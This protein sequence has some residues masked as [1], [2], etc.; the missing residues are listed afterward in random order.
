MAHLQANAAFVHRLASAL[1]GECGADLA[2]DA[3][4][5]SVQA[6]PRGCG[7]GS[8]WR[9]IV[10]RLAANA[11]RAERRRRAHHEARTAAL[12]GEDIVSLS[13]A[14]VLEREETRRR[15]LDAVLALEEPFR[16]VVLLRFYEG[17][18]D[19][20]VAGRLGIPVGTV[21]S[22][23]HR[24]LARLR[25]SFDPRRGGEALLWMTPRTLRDAVPTGAT[26]GVVL[27][28]KVCLL[29]ALLLLVVLAMV[30]RTRTPILEM[31]DEATA[32]NS[33]AVVAEPLGPAPIAAVP[34]RLDA[35]PGVV[36]RVVDLAGNAVADA[37]VFLGPD[38]APWLATDSVLSLGRTAG[39]GCAQ[40][41]AALFAGVETAGLALHASRTGYRIGRIAPTVVAAKLANGAALEV[42]LE[43]GHRQFFS[44]RTRSGAPVVGRAVVLARTE[45]LDAFLDAAAGRA[46]ATFEAVHRAVSDQDGR[47]TF[48]GLEP[49][50]YTFRVGVDN[51]LGVVSGR[52]ASEGVAVPGPPV[53]LVFDQVLAGGIVVR[54]DE[55]VTYRVEYYP[56]Q[57]GSSFAQSHESLLAMLRAASPGANLT[58]GCAWIGFPHERLLEPVVSWRL[59][60]ARTGWHE[61]K[62]RLL[63]LANGFEPEILTIPAETPDAPTGEVRLEWPASLPALPLLLRDVPRRSIRVVV[64]TGQVARLPAGRYEVVANLGGNPD[65]LAGPRIEIVAGEQVAVPLTL[66]EDVALA[67]VRA[68]YPSGRRVERATLRWGQYDRSGFFHMRGAGGGIVLLPVGTVDLVLTTFGCKDVPVRVEMLHD[69]VNTIELTVVGG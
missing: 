14:E 59:L 42:V 1:Y 47:V 4:L 63:P 64:P 15:V 23:Q 68:R 12:G 13:P 43:R 2:Q 52:R 41:D 33:T 31:S 36:V 19:Q 56:R 18:T 40:V 39:D 7:L 37:E 54:G 21:R 16:Q 38:L 44:L 35:I 20:Q 5:R 32:P 61:G 50:T 67:V 26:V 8:Y 22:R 65:L 11:S 10:G 3:L 53:E 28:K 60:L 6:P 24:A 62:T 48:E 46:G 55:V 51:S 34:Q 49:A 27:M 17:L 29:A 25:E 58:D 66:P 30:F 57:Q 45:G 9:T 69:R